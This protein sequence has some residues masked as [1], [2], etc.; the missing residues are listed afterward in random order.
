MAIDEQFGHMGDALRQ[1]GRLEA[2]SS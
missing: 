2:G 1:T